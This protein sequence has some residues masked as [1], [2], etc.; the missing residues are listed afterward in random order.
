MIALESSLFGRLVLPL[1]RF[2]LRAYEGSILAFLYRGLADFFTRLWRG[3]AAVHFLGKDGALDRGWRKSLFC[4]WF[5]VLINL[6][7]ILLRALYHTFRKVCDHSL[8]LKFGFAVVSETPVAV[9]W[10]MLVILIIP[11]DNWN[12]A[13]GLLG[14]GLMLVFAIL[15]SVKQQ[16]KRLDIADLGPYIVAFWGLVLFAWPL[17]AY[18]GLS[19]R[20]F[21]FHFACM[22]CVLVIVSTV[23]KARHLV[24]LASMATLGLCITS[25]YG[26]Y[27]RI[28]GVEVNTSYVD[29]TLN[30]GMP[31][32]IFSMFENPNAFGEVLVLLI[33]VA[34]CLIFAAKGFWGKCLG[35]AGTGLGCI[36]LAM[37]YSRAGWIGL[38]ISAV[39]FVFLWKRKLLPL[40]ALVALAAVPILPDTV[41]NRI[42]TIFNPA[43][44][45]T[46]SRFPLYAAALE[47]IQTRPQ[48]VGLGSEAVRAA[49][50]DMNLYHGKA[51]FVHCHNVYLQV[52]AETGLFGLLAL[53]GSAGWMLK[54][55]ARAA[56]G[57]LGNYETRMVVIGATSAIVGIMVCGFADF[58]WHYPRVMLVFWFVFAL[59]LSGIRLSRLEARGET[60]KKVRRT[61]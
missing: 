28:Q 43:D 5:G 20:Y 49:V 54:R 24:R 23:T 42:L 11:F 44:T 26:I 53:L 39:V 56:L 29:L 8:F 9:G 47:L 22:V 41:W 45:S 59:A 10:L 18:S 37:T 40:F 17:S 48:G 4:R 61:L 1:W 15:A 27:Q 57:K 13:Y 46:S 19:Q 12:N 38:L 35:L 51:P 14:F 33:P 58:I 36:A 52:W 16:S 32:R 30:K 60:A 25:L 31:G 21:F 34:V 3:S 55:A 7:G 6:P 50:S 2:L